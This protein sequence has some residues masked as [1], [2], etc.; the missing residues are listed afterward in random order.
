MEDKFN[1]WKAQVDGKPIEAEDPTNLYQ[2]MDLAFNWCDFLNIPRDTIRHLDAFQVYTEPNGD[3]ANYFDLIA[4]SPDNF[5]QVGDLVVW[6]Q[7][8]GYA[9]HI[10]VCSPIADVNSFI[11]EDQNWSG[12][13]KATAVKHSYNG[14]LGWLRPKLTTANPPAN[15][16]PMPDY[17]TGLFEAQNLNPQDE[18]AVRTFWQQAIDFPSCN[19]DKINAQTALATA[20]NQISEFQ[21]QV[22]NLKT[23]NDQQAAMIESLQKDL[24]N[25]QQTPNFTP[26]TGLGKFFLSLSRS[27]G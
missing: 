14:V 3:T 25:A 9:G 7:S 26:K 13:Q 22:T 23:A 15:I 8:V 21:G 2:C 19:T 18:P 12:V 5:P 1:Q 27:L 16:K 17:L 6:G 4:N 11:S 10:A 24:Q 20:N